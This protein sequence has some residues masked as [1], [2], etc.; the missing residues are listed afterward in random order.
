MSVEADRATRQFQQGSPAF[1]VIRRA[2]HSDGMQEC[3]TEP[4]VRRD[5][6]IRVRIAIERAC[7]L[8]ASAGTWSGTCEFRR[9]FAISQATRRA[10]EFNGEYPRII[11]RQPVR[12][13]P[14]G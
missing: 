8:T 14:S 13:R 10:V 6:D 5:A 7:I 11:G 3:A 12:A 4:D 1:A 9:A 2:A